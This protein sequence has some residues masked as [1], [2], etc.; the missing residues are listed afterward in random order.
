MSDMLVSAV[1]CPCYTHHAIFQAGFFELFG[2]SKAYDVNR[3]PGLEFQH[4]Y[5]NG[6]AIDMKGDLF[7]DRMAWATP[8]CGCT[9]FEKVRIKMP[10]LA[11][12]VSR[13]YE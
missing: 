6:I 5:P 11:R 9:V 2:K 13:P 7:V 4:S 3:I 8:A 10:I 12:P 1:S